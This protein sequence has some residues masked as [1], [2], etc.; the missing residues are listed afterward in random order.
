VLI[1]SLIP[2]IFLFTIG[3]LISKFIPRIEEFNAAERIAIMFGLGLLIAILTS[4]VL[5]WF[6][7]TSLILPVSILELTV[8]AAILSV[9]AL[10][11]SK[12]I[13]FIPKMPSRTFVV[14]AVLLVFCFLM[15]SFRP[16][17]FIRTPDDYKNVFWAKNMMTNNIVAPGGLGINGSDYSSEIWP[18]VQRIAYGLSLVYFFKMGDYSLL[19]GQILSALF[20]SILILASFLIGSLR[21][22]KTG[23]IVAILV[24]FNPLIFLFSDHIMTDIPAAAIG[25]LALYFF[26]RSYESNRINRRFLLFALIFAGISVLTK[27]TAL[28]LYPFVSAYA[29]WGQPFKIRKIELIGRLL[30]IIVFASSFMTDALRIVFTGI[31]SNSWKIFVDPLKIFTWSFSDW[32]KYLTSSPLGGYGT[33]IFPYLYT[34]PVALLVLMGCLY[35]VTKERGKLNILFFATLMFVLWEFTTSP[36]LTAFVRHVFI[37]FPIIMYFAAIGI[38]SRRYSIVAIPFFLLLLLVPEQGYVPYVQNSILPEGFRTIMKF[39][40]VTVVGLILLADFPLKKQNRKLIL[41]FM[42]T[43]RRRTLTISL[44]HL[45]VIAIICITISASFYSGIFYLQNAPLEVNE[46][47]TVESAGIKQAVIWVDSNIPQ[48]SRIATNNFY[49]FP[50]YL[51]YLS[52]KNYTLVYLPGARTSLS[53]ADEGLNAFLNLTSS[54][55]VDYLIIFTFLSYMHWYPYLGNYIDNPPSG[56][57]EVNRTSTFVVYKTWSQSGKIGWEGNFSQGWNK[58]WSKDPRSSYQM[59]SYGTEMI[60]GTLH[61]FGLS[62]TGDNTPWAHWVAISTSLPSINI[63]RYPYL[64]SEYRNTNGTEYQVGIVID[65][66]VFFPIVAID[67]GKMISV[68]DMRKYLPSGTASEIFLLT[69][70]LSENM[71]I[72]LYIDRMF[73]TSAIG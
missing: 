61:V 1:L 56:M 29:L 35:M 7:L 51:T 17:D 43:A 55:R 48:Y 59:A 15:V 38:Q 39:M 54:Q 11:K 27:G 45:S 25:I 12:K 73:F 20:Y 8:P 62:E 49:E 44:R 63:S 2:V 6:N 42:N 19:T 58:G 26:I 32:T 21:N 5:G 30:P 4:F 16:V 69:R 37:V 46:K 47:I 66:Q 52:S 40:G 23:L 72:D 60:D 10:H 64:V 9:Y 53:S 68:V 36:A 50:F 28:F 3:F 71:T 18:W 31:P 65:G 13:R 70:S 41:G 57:Y 22:K 24:A 67:S 34:F 33:F 14:L